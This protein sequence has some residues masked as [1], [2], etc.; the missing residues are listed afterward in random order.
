MVQRSERLQKYSN[1]GPLTSKTFDS[2]IREG[3]S[4]DEHTQ[5]L[6]ARIF[7]TSRA[8]AINPDG[9]LVLMGPSGTGKTHI[10]AAIANERIAQ[11]QPA[12][13]VVTPDLL[14]HLRSAF[15]PGS[16]RTYAELFEQVRNAPLLVLDDLGANSSTA[17]AQE[18]LLQLINHR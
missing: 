4:P 13:F 9:W 17:W 6:F 7:D 8:F 16:A 2:L 14:D 11:G 3:Q 1:L 18:K 10:A 12:L 5:E 15:G